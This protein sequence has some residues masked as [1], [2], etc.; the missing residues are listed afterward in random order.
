MIGLP[1]CVMH[2]LYTRDQRRFSAELAVCRRLQF[3]DMLATRTV[4]VTVT[5]C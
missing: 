5:V 2:V 1:V 4:P 3:A